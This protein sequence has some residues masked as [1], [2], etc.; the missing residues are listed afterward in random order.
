MANTIRIKR[1]ESGSPGAPSSLASAELAFNEVDN[2]LYFGSGNNGSD[3]AT[4]IISI[5][6]N[7]AFV[8]LSSAQTVGGVKT[9]SSTIV[10]SVSGNAGTATAWATA[11]DLSL[12][13]DATATLSSVDGTA[14]VSAALTLATVNSNVGAFTKL[15]VNGKGL[16]TAASQASLS[17]LSAPT[18]DF[19]F[20]SYKLTDLATPTLSTDAATKGYVDSVTTPTSFDF[21]DSVIVASNSNETISAPGATIDGV[22]LTSGDRVLLIGQ[23]AG[24]DNGI[25]VFNGAAVP[26]TRSTDANTSAEVTNG[27][28]IANIQSGTFASDR[29]VLITA[30]PI[31]LGTTPL[32]FAVQP[33]AGLTGDGTT[34]TVSGSTISIYSGY[35]GQTSIT[36][37][38]TVTTGTWNGST[39]AVANGGTGATSIT[40]LVKGNGTSAFTA[41]VEGTDYL[42]PTSTIDGGTF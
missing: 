32:V 25:Y 16:V 5:A 18:A 27:M 34:I 26:M 9:F 3:V 36:T 41:A 1:R 38:G 10:G 12:T 39:I 2:V 23:T 21:K 17:D 11:R 8:D 35:V 37:L 24:Q 30:D 6:G 13:G 22:T 14:N 33:N 4:S 7:G 19:S 42:S 20:G 31:V 29:A 40:G 28:T 15:T